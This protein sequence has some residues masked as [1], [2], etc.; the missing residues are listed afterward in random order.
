M[1]RV[2]LK[3]LEKLKDFGY[4]KAGDLGGW[5]E[6]NEAEYPLLEELE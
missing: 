2:K 6:N 1:I 4:V 5:V 3:D